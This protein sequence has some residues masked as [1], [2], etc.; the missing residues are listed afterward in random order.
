MNGGAEECSNDAWWIVFHQQGREV[1]DTGRLS[2]ISMESVPLP[3]LEQDVELQYKSGPSLGE[4][5]NC[6]TFRY[7]HRGGAE[8]V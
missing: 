4:L 1:T 5:Y 3:L 2:I 6:D 8:K 7:E